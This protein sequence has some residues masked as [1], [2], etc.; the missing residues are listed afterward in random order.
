MTNIP[1]EIKSMEDIAGLYLRRWP[2]P[3]ESFEDMGRNKISDRA[4]R[5]KPHFGC[6]SYVHNVGY[7]NYNDINK[8]NE[9]FPHLLDNLNIYVQQ[10]YFSAKYSENSLPQMRQ[11]FYAL[12]G[13]ISSEKGCFLLELFSPRTS[14]KPAY[15]QDLLYA[16]RRVNESSASILGKRLIVLP[17]KIS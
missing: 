7:H 9:I 15:E 17:E 10:R 1:L 4:A 16:A 8:L 3:E 6:T 12:D 11:E 2:E 5:G 14:P 13:K